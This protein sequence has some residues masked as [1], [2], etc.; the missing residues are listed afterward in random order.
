MDEIIV[1]GGGGSLAV[2]ICRLPRWVSAVLFQPLKFFADF[3]L[4]VPGIF[5]EGMSFAGKDQQRARHS[6]IVQGVIEQ[7]IFAYGDANVI[8][9]PDNVSRGADFVD[10]VDGV[11][12]VISLLCYTR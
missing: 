5:G 1:V 10:L 7:I 12:V 4:S 8:G 9:A 6:Q 3:D 2:A 11:F